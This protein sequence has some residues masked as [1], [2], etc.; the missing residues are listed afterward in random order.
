MFTSVRSSI[1]KESFAMFGIIFGTLC[2]IALIATIRRE[3]YFRRHGYPQYPYGHHGCG[4][5]YHH[6]H[7]SHEP[8]AAGAPPSA[9]TAAP[10]GSAS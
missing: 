10:E 2:L 4:C 9:G 3:R 5:G 8:P 7:R 1:G 6:H